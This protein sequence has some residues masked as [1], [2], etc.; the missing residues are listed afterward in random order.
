MS[1][2]ILAWHFLANDKRLR[3]GDGRLVKA[4]KTYDTTGPLVMCHNGVHG[5]RKI[6][7]AL[8]YA[9]G[10][11]VCR[12]ELSGEM[13]TEPPD[14]R[15]KVCARSRR[16]LWMVDATMLLHEFACRCAED[17][18][19]LTDTPDPRSVEAI[20]VKRLWM[21]GKATDAELDAA[22]DAA[23]DTA[24]DAARDAAWDAAWAAA[25][26]AARAAAWDAQNARLE[27]MLLEL[28]P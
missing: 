1:K 16:V 7:D 28:V 14:N 23:W 9:P 27:K 8:N 17:A 25:W 22:W 6:L 15:D 11:I 2:T 3:Y 13:F 4:G 12:V 19:A 10:P 5:C 24:R 18:L 26:D 20:R 21:A